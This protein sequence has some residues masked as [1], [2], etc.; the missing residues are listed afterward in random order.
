MQKVSNPTIESEFDRFL[1]ELPFKEFPYSKRNWGDPL[2]SLCSFSGKL[3]PSLAHHLINKFTSEGEKVFDFFSGSGTVPFEASLQSRISFGLDINPIAVAISKGKVGIPNEVDCM[4]I[5][6]DLRNHIDNFILQPTV[7]EKAGAF[8]FNKT[9]IE[10]YHENTFAE[11]LKA[12][13]FFLNYPNKN[14]SYYLILGSLLHI[15]H[16]NRPY[17]LS[18]KSHPI[19]PYAPTGEYEYKS[20]HEKLSDKVFKG[21][22]TNK[23]EGF[24]RGNIYQG[25]IMKNWNEDIKDVNAIISSP[26]FF[27]STKFYLTNWIRSWFMGWENEDFE[28]EKEAFIETKQKKSFELYNEIFV[29]AKDRLTNNGIMI[30]HLGKSDKKDMGEIILPIAKKYFQ[31]AK[32][33]NEDV[34][35]VENHGMT[36]KGSVNVHQYILAH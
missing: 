22:K 7:I 26:P 13:D 10:Y 27:E 31:T 32:L 5:L 3:K 18:R 36:D 21:L 2:H 35:M 20:L 34:S 12:R 1:I 28:L 23:S 14:D 4:N 6:L 9:L 17:A 19:T 29:Q 25:D 8:G 30:L 15:L 33:Y 16:G 24:N 11:I